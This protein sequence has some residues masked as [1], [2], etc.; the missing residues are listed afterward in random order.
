MAQEFR[1]INK[2]AGSDAFTIEVDHFYV[3][4]EQIPT[5]GTE[6]ESNSAEPQVA[7]ES[8]YITSTF[9]VPAA[10]IERARKRQ[11]KSEVHDKIA[12]Q[13]VAYFQNLDMT[14][15][16]NVASLAMKD[17]LGNSLVHMAVKKSNFELIRVLIENCRMDVNNKVICALLGSYFSGQIF[18]RIEGYFTEKK[19]CQALNR[20]GAAII[21]NAPSQNTPK[22]KKNL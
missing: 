15:S 1:V 10:L 7:P 4:G 5:N 12:N 3:E 9:E 18:S 2:C 21:V 17:S 13:D 19:T 11:D 16:K 14:N 22:L 20:Y 6:G 8:G